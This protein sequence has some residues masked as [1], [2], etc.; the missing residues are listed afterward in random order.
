MGGVYSVYGAVWYVMRG[1]EEREGAGRPCRAV[2][3]C[4]GVASRQ[5]SRQSLCAACACRPVLVCARLGGAR[6]ARGAARG[7]RGRASSRSAAQRRDRE[8]ATLRHAAKDSVVTAPRRARGR[9][10]RTP[11][12]P[13]AKGRAARAAVVVG[14]CECA[15]ASVLNRIRSSRSGGRDC[16]TYVTAI[17]RMLCQ[18]SLRTVRKENITRI[19]PS[20]PHHATHSALPCYRH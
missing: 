9:H 8:L 3:P 17:V 15:T 6:L 16:H 11:R 13:G 14:K 7:I 12:G 1:C 20:T 4:H 5:Q 10:A 19:Y 2:L 18:L